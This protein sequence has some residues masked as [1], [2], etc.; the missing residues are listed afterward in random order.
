MEEIEDINVIEEPIIFINDESDFIS[1]ENT[2]K[3]INDGEFIYGIKNKLGSGQFGKIY[4][5]ITPL[6]RN[7]AIKIIDKFRLKL[8]DDL[9]NIQ[10]EILIHGNLKHKNIVNFEKVYQSSNKI[11]ILLELCKNDLSH[12]YKTDICTERFSKF[13]IKNIVE[14][15]MYLHEKLIVHR[16]IKLENILIDEN[17]NVKI[18]DFGFARQLIDSEEL[19]FSHVGTLEYFSPEIVNNTGHSLNTDI[20]SL[21]VLFYELLFKVTP[22]E[23]E[24]IRATYRKITQCKYKIPK[25]HSIDDNSLNVIKGAL[26]VNRE[27]RI[28]LFNIL[29]ELRND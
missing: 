17:N 15:L 6:G 25:I 7:I 22:F 21:G 16:D 26:T 28:T 27:E 8:S 29:L 1:S 4:N 3:Q 10:N 9:D 18:G 2:N 14:A 24:G 20:W 12:I 13:I 23:S 5:C 19:L 11:F